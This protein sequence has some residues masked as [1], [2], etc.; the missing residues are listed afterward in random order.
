MPF[1]IVAPNPKYHKPNNRKEYCKKNNAVNG[2]EIVNKE[3][4][5]DDYPNSQKK[6]K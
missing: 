1:S 2:K 3:K 4:R 5:L 6:S